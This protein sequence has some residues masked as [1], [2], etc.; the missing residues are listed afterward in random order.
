MTEI[1]DENTIPIENVTSLEPRTNEFIAEEE[2]SL[3]SLDRE[4]TKQAIHALLF[5]SDKPLSANRIAEI[6]GDIDTEVV[7]SLLEEIKIEINN[8]NNLPYILKEIAGG[9]QLLT[10]PLFAPFIRKFLQI[11]RT[12][13]MSPALLETLAII[14]YKQ[15]ITRVEVEA[16]RG[17]SVTHAFEQLLEQNL[18]KVCGVSELP[19]RPKLYRT[20]DEF[21]LM[22]GLNSL[23]DLPSVE[24]LKEFK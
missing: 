8:N 14:A 2:E 16:I 22:F 17:V 24:D 6:L 12:R 11:K 10:R 15:P 21:L 9:Y 23:Q 18:I 20:T 1:K 7:I 4:Q 3:S 13:R 5:V 19:G